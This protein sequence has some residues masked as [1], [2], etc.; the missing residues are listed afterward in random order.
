MSL[1]LP[2]LQ[3]VS[4]SQSSCVSP[5]ELTNW[6]GREWWARSQIIRP[7]ESLTLYKSFNTLCSTA[8]GCGQIKGLYTRLDWPARDIIREA[9]EVAWAA[10]YLKNSETQSLKYMYSFWGLNK[11]ADS[12]YADL[13]MWT[14]SDYNAKLLRL[15][16]ILRW[17]GTSN[18][19]TLHSTDLFVHCSAPV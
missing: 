9:L 11:S 3:V 15:P 13:V 7:R 8:T 19:M 18:L 2:D 17:A 4:L 12:G 6:R 10:S 16:L 14:C 5:V 1:L